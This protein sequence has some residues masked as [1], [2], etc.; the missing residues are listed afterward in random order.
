M[1]SLL[2]EAPEIVKA[3]QDDFGTVP[4]LLEDLAILAERIV[5]L[6]KDQTV[7]NKVSFSRCLTMLKSEV[8]ALRDLVNTR[9]RPPEKVGVV[10]NS[11]VKLV[12]KISDLLQ[13]AQ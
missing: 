12:K 1:H 4:Q 10:I 8:A 7:Q 9:N 6:S 3:V 2:T 11:I 13:A 5:E